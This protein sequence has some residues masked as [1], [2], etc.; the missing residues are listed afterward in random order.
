LLNYVCWVDKIIFVS[1]NVS[2]G[3]ISVVGGDRASSATSAK[4]LSRASF[5]WGRQITTSGDN[6]NNGLET[7]ERDGAGMEAPSHWLFCY[8]MSLTRFLV[9]LGEKR[10]DDLPALPSTLMALPPTEPITAP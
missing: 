9:G 6:V 4:C 10:K 3:V 1:F 2:G 5:W 7:E 8:W